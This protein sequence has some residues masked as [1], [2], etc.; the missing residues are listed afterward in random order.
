MRKLFLI[1]G[2]ITVVLGVA[3][4]VS[5]VNT[6]QVNARAGQLNADI[7]NLFVGFQTYKEHVGEYPRGNNA[8][9]VKAL[10]G[11]NPKNVII[12]VG[13][14]NDVNS[15]GEVV[16]PWG[17]ALRFY[18]AGDGILIRSAGPNRRFDDSTSLEMD[19]YFRSN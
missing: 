16:D 18:F 19:D 3:W 8:Q 2:V 1:V 11:K 6:W 4:V 14:K 15:Q 5:S 17:T 10:L 12:L 7:E 13:Q 9:I